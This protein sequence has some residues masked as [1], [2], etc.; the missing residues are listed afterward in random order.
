[1]ILSVCQSICLFLFHTTAHY[2][3]TWFHCA[4]TAE[5]I[6]IQL[7]V[8]NV[9]KPMNIILNGIPDFPH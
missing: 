8:E 7:G 2:H 4:H 3:N 5:R 1:M 6:E 9:G